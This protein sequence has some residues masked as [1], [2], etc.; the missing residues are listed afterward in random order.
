MMQLLELTQLVVKV[1]TKLAQCRFK[2]DEGW[3][4]CCMTDIA[5]RSYQSNHFSMF[6]TIYSK[7]IAI[8]AVH[9]PQIEMFT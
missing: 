5:D 9:V 6:C 1:N 2:Y 7:N 4:H 8:T 3:I